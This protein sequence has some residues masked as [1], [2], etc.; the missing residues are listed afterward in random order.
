[1]IKSMRKEMGPKNG[2]RLKTGTP[3]PL[4]VKNAF[5]S[6]KGISAPL[7][8]VVRNNDGVREK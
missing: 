5:C 1:M 4:Y 6:I 3:I 2:T 7:G 8:R